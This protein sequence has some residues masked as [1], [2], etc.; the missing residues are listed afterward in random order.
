MT[1]VTSP[2]SPGC[3]GPSCGAVSATF[4]GP[5]RDQQ[6]LPWAR[7]DFSSGSAAGS[8][9]G[10]HQ[11]WAWPSLLAQAALGLGICPERLT[12]RGVWGGCES[13]EG[14]W[15]PEH[16]CR[17]RNLACLGRAFRAHGG[18]CPDAST[19]GQ[20]CCRW[21]SLELHPGGRRGWPPGARCPV[22]GCLQTSSVTEPGAPIG[23]LAQCLQFRDLL[24]A[25]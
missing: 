21:N 1:S 8:S 23:A 22:A 15:L 10:F 19:R 24:S 5:Q 3:P 17:L 25:V 18:G 6:S 7:R 20:L 4:S 2:C 13:G 12:A 11:N 9:E 14:A 16:S